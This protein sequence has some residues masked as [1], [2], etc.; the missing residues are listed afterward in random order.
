M[1]PLHWIAICVLCFMS[2]GFIGYF[3]HCVTLAKN[4][5]VAGSLYFYPDGDQELFAEIEKDKF[6]EKDGYVIME[7]VHCNPKKV[8]EKTG[9]MTE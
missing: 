1:E 6:P 3:L 9:P 8:A 2:G 5:N 4:M 7:L